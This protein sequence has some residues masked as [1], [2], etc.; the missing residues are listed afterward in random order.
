MF[1]IL[2]NGYIYI[3]TGEKPKQIS[4]N[5][6]LYFKQ[7]LS[8]MRRFLTFY[9][10]LSGLVGILN[11]GVTNF[12]EHFNEAKIF[13]S[14]L[15]VAL[16]IIFLMFV[17]GIQI[18]RSKK[19]SPWLIYVIFLPQVISF[20]TPIFSYQFYSGTSIIFLHNFKDNIT[21][22]DFQILYTKLRVLF[23]SNNLIFGV[24]IIPII[25]IILLSV[26]PLSHARVP[27]Q[28]SSVM[29]DL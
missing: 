23:S 28:S 14:F 22:I 1:A 8:N 13:F 10:F 7:L 16:L 3:F 2:G 27:H 26:P 20:E 19:I 11:L 24:D 9:M 12:I 6:N 17:L 18:Y 25:I 15:V 5:F 4:D 29:L 21:S